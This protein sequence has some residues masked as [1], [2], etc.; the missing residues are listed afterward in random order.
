MIGFII[1]F[2]FD[3][4]NNLMVEPMRRRWRK[5]CNYDCSRCKVWD[6]S[7]HLCIEQKEKENRKRKKKMN[8]EKDIKSFRK[9]LVKYFNMSYK[10]KNK[11]IVKVA[12]RDIQLSNFLNKIKFFNIEQQEKLFAQYD[13]PEVNNWL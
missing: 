3:C 9:F 7:R 11:L 13:N 6:C 2:A 4:F 12:K 8:N 1:G 10:Q 5:E